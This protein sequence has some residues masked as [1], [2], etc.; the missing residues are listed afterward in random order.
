[1]SVTDQV[2]APVRGCQ[3]TWDAC[4]RVFLVPWIHLIGELMSAQSAAKAPW[5]LSHCTLFLK[6]E[7]LSILRNRTRVARPAR[8]QMQ[9]VI[10][11]GPRFRRLEEGSSAAF[12]RSR[13][14]PSPTRPSSA[15]KFLASPATAMAP[16]SRQRIRA[17]AQTARTRRPC[18]P[19]LLRKVP[20]H[21]RL[22]DLT[23]AGQH[24]DLEVLGVLG[25]H[26]LNGSL[27]VHYFAALSN[28]EAV[29]DLRRFAPSELAA[30]QYTR[31]VRPRRVNE[32]RRAM[33][34]GA[35]LGARCL[36]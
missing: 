21:G 31:E 13:I 18:A 6:N 11:L 14:A 7:K 24:D 4:N 32:K 25:H 10:L 1:M 19:L 27:D 3:D 36:I 33:T 5:W 20:Q 16:S 12:L 29:L 35:L 26:G 17:S 2:H 34:S 30:E 15:P 28:P 22:A 23:R 9:Q 8:R